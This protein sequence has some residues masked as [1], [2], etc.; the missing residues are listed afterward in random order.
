MKGKWA[1][2]AAVQKAIS[3]LP[4][5]QRVNYLFQDRV[6][7]STTL[8]DAMVEQRLGWAVM[9]LEA[10]DR[11]GGSREGFRAVELGSGWYPI[12]PLA[13]FL[14]GADEVAMVDLEDLTRPELV[15]Q[16]IDQLVA[17]A[18]DGRL[19]ELGPIDP[20]RVDRLRALRPRVE[21]DHAA[22]LAELGL[23]ITPGDARELV[24]D[25]PPD[26]ISSNTVFEHISPDVLE[27]ILARFGAIAGP[28]TVMS[29]LVDHG[30]H[31]AY[32]DDTIDIHHFLRYSDRVWRLID[33]DVQPMN[34]LRASEYVAMYHRLE[35][36]LTEE[37]HRDCDPMTL[38]G[39]PLADRFR[40]M[41]PADV[42]CAASHLVTRFP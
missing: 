34:R 33:N 37:H 3:F 27:G 5:P 30:D 42:A 39:I 40:A 35:L 9:H 23:R 19:V 1:A 32:L 12:V 26:L 2:K 36:P 29:H 25:V 17:A 41:D 14:A 38:V 11:H 20:G 15:V 13:L 6:T 31:Y 24:L 18:D 28:G 21:R 4:D 7:K 8:T 16:A 10:F 22:A